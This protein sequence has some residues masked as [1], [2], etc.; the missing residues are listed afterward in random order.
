ME[1]LNISNRSSIISAIRSRYRGLVDAFIEENQYLSEYRD[2]YDP[3]K[4]N[5]VK[6]LCDG[7]HY[8]LF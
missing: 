6:L 3:T 7:N 4:V 8:G 2:T 5:V 1:D